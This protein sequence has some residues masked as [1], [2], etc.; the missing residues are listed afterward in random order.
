M[1][2]LMQKERKQ[3]EDA[4]TKCKNLLRCRICKRNYF[5][6][7]MFQLESRPGK[8]EEFLENILLD[9]IYIY[10]NDIRFRNVSN[11]YIEFTNK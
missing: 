9:M 7:R 4:H 5:L 6:A 3:I 1:P 11:F 8:N 10:F 2:I